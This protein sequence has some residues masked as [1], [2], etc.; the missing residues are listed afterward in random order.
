MSGF[1]IAG[2][3]AGLSGAAIYE[4]S[5]WVGLSRERRLPFYLYKLHYW[6]LTVLQILAGA[7]AAGYL[8]PTGGASAFLVG[9]AGPSL[10]SRLGA[11]T[12]E[13]AHLG[14]DQTVE[15]QDSPASWFRG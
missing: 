5:R 9:L 6:L 3:L 7:V 10:L 14:T 8:T 4:A 11:L 13:K 12:L 2:F 1:T 15:R